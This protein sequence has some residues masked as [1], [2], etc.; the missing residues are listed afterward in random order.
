MSPDMPQAGTL[1]INTTKAGAFAERGYTIHRRVPFT[2]YRVPF[3]V[4]RSKE[5]AS[6]F[7]IWI[8]DKY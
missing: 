7:E 6:L 8:L 5:L 2:V 1:A 4:H 3:T